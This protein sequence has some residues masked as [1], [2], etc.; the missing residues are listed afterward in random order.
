[1]CVNVCP[2]QIEEV[3]LKSGDYVSPNYQILVDRENNTDTFQ[4]DVELSEAAQSCSAEELAKISKTIAAKLKSTLGISPKL[5][6]L[7]PKTIARSEG[8]AKRVIDKRK[9]H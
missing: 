9:L 1:M 6:L 4:V 2:S 7:P 8:K 5:N 3:L